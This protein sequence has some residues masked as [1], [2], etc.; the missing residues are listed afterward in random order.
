ML[1]LLRLLSIVVMLGSFVGA[2]AQQKVLI[3]EKIERATN[4]DDKGLTQW[5]EWK[6]EKCPS[7]SGSGKVKCTTCERFQDDATVCI[8]CGR[9]KERQAVCRMCAGVGTLPDPLEKVG[10]PACLGASFLLCTI[11][12]GGGRLKIGDDKRFGDC[13]ACR[14]AGGWKCGVCNGARL[15]ETA[16]LKPS[17]KD[18]ATKDLVKALAATDQ[19]LKDLGAVNPAGGDK[20]RKDVKALLAAFQV[21]QAYHPA[22]RRLGKP[23]EDYMAKIYAGKQFQGA[24]ENEAATMAMVKN[25]AEYY[26]KHQKRM[27]ELVQKRAEANEK[28]AA[29]QKGK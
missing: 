26:L 4:T 20:S 15:V 19:A 14:G 16:A 25:S 11:C 22:L 5:V 10:C 21:A 27:M 13:V 28:L 6:A 2:V 23:F 8:D 24:A 9:N 3:P 1:A 18:A 7:C 12:R 17:L 29:E